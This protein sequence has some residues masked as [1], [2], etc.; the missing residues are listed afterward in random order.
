[1]SLVS[2][3]VAST[4]RPKIP[5]K[6]VRNRCAVVCMFWFCSSLICVKH[7]PSHFTT[8]CELFLFE[9]VSGSGGSAFNPVLRAIGG[10]KSSRLH[11]PTRAATSAETLA[12]DTFA[13]VRS[14]EIKHTKTS[15][16]SAQLALASNALSSVSPSDVVEGRCFSDAFEYVP[17]FVRVF[18]C[19]DSFLKA[20]IANCHQ[21][22]RILAKRPQRA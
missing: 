7:T 5:S 12:A 6:E 15:G 3:E 8:L 21:A 13:G 22:W 11:T 18:L 20:A 4:T 2:L 17:C 19:F 1:M 16:S 9:Q 10:T 14:S